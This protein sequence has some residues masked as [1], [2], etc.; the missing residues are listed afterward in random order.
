MKKGFTLI[1]VILALA[2]GGLILLAAS[3]LLMSLTQLWMKEKGLDNFED[4][5]YG[6][7]EFLKEHL[8]EAQYSPDKG[9]PKTQWGKPP[10]G[11]GDEQY[12][13]FYIRTPHPLFDTEELNPIIAYLVWTKDE[14]LSLIWYSYK[15]DVPLDKV[16]AY[17][18][19]LSP[20]VKG[21]KLHYYDKERG[22]WEAVT[23][24]KENKER[25]LELP[26]FL[27]LDF[28]KEGEEAQLSYIWLPK[29]SAPAK[30]K[31]SA[32]PGVPVKPSG[33]Q[34]KPSSKRPGS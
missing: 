12:L 15:P 25:K 4:H 17:R 31:A 18:R 1:E 10:V 7:T 30:P 32:K 8:R 6:V 34:S 2:L 26:D 5:V 13:M 27:E 9:L 29:P 19:I 23:K 24:P 16:E 11:S 20:Y 28:E 33:P 14:G 3:S 22:R 21:I